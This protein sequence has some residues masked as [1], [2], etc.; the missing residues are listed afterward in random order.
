MSSA[1]APPNDRFLLR[2]VQF[3]QFWCARVAAD[4]GIAMLVFALSTSFLLPLA[5]LCLLG[6]F[7]MVRVVIRSTLVQLET[8]DAM[9]GRAVNAMFVT[10][11][12][13]LSEFES[14]VTASW[15]GTVPAVMI[16]GLGAFAAVGLWMWWFPAWRKYER[17][18]SAVTS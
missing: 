18:E 1:A 3:R 17:L 2:H 14:G 8:P 16:G 12:N 6:A 9:R 13:Q 11:S 15:F 7:D 5:V 4:F 10:A